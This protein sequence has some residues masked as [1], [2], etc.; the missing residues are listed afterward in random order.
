MATFI[1][2]VPYNG[3]GFVAIRSSAIVAVHPVFEK[4][5]D[6]F[7]YSRVVTDAEVFHVN[8]VWEQIDAAMN[9]DGFT[10]PTPT[11]AKVFG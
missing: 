7:L 6:V 10:V 8:E 9:A 5:S 11:L 3:G 4:D 2:C 1:E